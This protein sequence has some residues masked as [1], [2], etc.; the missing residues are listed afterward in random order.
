[1][2]GSKTYTANKVNE[3]FEVEFI[4]DIGTME[5]QRLSGIS[6]KLFLEVIKI[7]ISL[8]VTTL[9]NRSILP[10]GDEPISLYDLMLIISKY[11][12]VFILAYVIV[13]GLAIVG[14]WFFNAFFNK[15]L[16][17][18][19]KKKAYLNFHK[20]IVN[21]IYLA[22]SFENKYNMY[23]TLSGEQSNSLN[24]DLAAIYLSQS[25]HYFK[26]AYEELCEL[27]PPKRKGKAEKRN[28]SFMDYMG[29]PLVNVSLISGQRSLERLLENQNVISDYIE[30]IKA[31]SN[32]GIIKTTYLNS[33]KEL[34]VEIKFYKNKYESFL[35]RSVALQNIISKNQ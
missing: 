28:A 12:L 20:K 18:S 7:C 32:E 8:F 17:C 14:K 22:I 35:E 19:E 27:V 31:K 2:P 10:N 5:K 4:N 6:F 23:I 33:I 1:M 15:R 29:Y 21:H 9:I 30:N 24:L 26:I 16:L 13:Y 11:I 25:V 3:L 34:Y